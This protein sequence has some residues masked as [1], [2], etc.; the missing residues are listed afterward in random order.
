[1]IRSVM[2]L[3]QK[4]SE[5]VP[6]FL[7]DTHLKL[8]LFGGKGGVGKTTSAATTALYLAL[9]FPQRNFLVVSTDPAH[10]L[11]DCFAGSILPPNLKLLE[12]DAQ[13]SLKKFKDAHVQHL[14]EIA[15]RGTIFD[16]EDVKG[17]LDLSMPGLDEVMAFLD[18]SDLVK[19]GAYSCVIMDTAPTGHTLRLLELPGIMKKWTSTLDLMLSKHRYLAKLYRGHYR[20][21]EVDLFLNKLLTAI[22]RLGFLLHDPLRCLFVPVMLGE[23]LSIYETRRLIDQL[24]IIRIPVRDILVNRLYPTELDCQVCRQAS[25]Q[26]RL[27]LHAFSQEFTD[28]SFWELQL[29]KAEVRGVERLSTFW[30]TVRP[31]GQLQ[32][33]VEPNRVPALLSRVENPIKL[34]GKEITLLLFAGKG[35]V[36]KTTLACATAVRLAKEY[37]SKKTFL[38]STDPAHSLSD[39]LGTQIGPRETSLCPGL[40][41]MEVDAV[42]EFEKLKKQYVDEV[43]QFFD[44]LAGQ[45]E[46]DVKFDRDVMERFMDLTPPGLDEVMSLTRIT[47]FLDAGKYDI[48]VL[49]TAPTGHLMRWLE[50]PELMEEWLKFFFKLTLKYERV[51]RLP[52]ITK[53]MTT[54]SR[55]IRALRSWLT[56]PKRGNLFPVSILTEMA[57]EETRDLFAV[58]QKEKIYVPAIFLNLATP[59]NKCSF[60]SSIAQSESRVRDKFGNAFKNIYQPVVY[61]C[62]EPRGLNRLEELGS[63]IYS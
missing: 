34:P 54:L 2:E 27:E 9:H 10:S 57:F 51:F 62:S 19:S 36:G 14:R 55:R 21:D 18:I 32:D 60:C 15:L 50:L 29:Q 49:D 13:E 31:L 56:D 16:D 8:L 28:F 58:C 61:R 23:L 43:E 11:G 42:A 22:D 40:T 63:V 30:D 20:K 39:C 1:M 5:H 48:F 24:K 12:I 17:L 7:C 44:S 4:T 3:A 52:K 41:A 35:G 45:A 37:P 25:L 46:V 33:K 59:I 38:F 6:T 26:Q 53:F 47:E